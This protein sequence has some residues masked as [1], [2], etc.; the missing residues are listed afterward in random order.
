MMFITDPG[1]LAGGG[2]HDGGRRRRNP[3]CTLPYFSKRR[4]LLLYT[5]NNSKYLRCGRSTGRRSNEPNGQRTEFVE[6]VLRYLSHLYPPTT[7]LLEALYPPLRRR[8]GEL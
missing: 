4:H 6:M 2:L 8:G 3:C 7:L 1:V 5:F